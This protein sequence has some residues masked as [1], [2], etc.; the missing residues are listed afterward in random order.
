M[1]HSSYNSFKDVTEI[2]KSMFPD[3]EIAKK[4]TLSCSKIAYLVAF[5]LAHY[6]HK[7][8]LCKI[9]DN[10]FLLCIDEALNRE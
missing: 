6:F 8:F 5:G 3:S 9:S 1:T 10:S 2:L 4:I 7:K